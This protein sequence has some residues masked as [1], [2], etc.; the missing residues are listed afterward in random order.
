MDSL[1]KFKKRM[2]LGGRSTVERLIKQSQRVAEDRF[3]TSASFYVIDVE[4]EAVESI[5]NR[6]NDYHIKLVHFKYDYDIK[7]GSIVA[8]DDKQYLI[9]DKDRDSVFSFAK[10]EECNGFF[11]LSTGEVE[12]IRVGTGEFGQ[13]IY[14]EKIVTIKEP[15]II[16]NKY[17]SISDNA[18]LP[19]SEG[20]IEISMKYQKASNVD[21]NE[22]FE[23]YGNTYVITDVGYNDVKNEVGIMKIYAERRDDRE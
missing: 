13:P 2:G 19:L 17:Y 21:V 7:I 23:L 14:E 1:D 16:K 11:D 18:A 12:R 8:F 15:C 22:I 6:T 3:K 10:M 5:V 20:Q 9:I 4:G